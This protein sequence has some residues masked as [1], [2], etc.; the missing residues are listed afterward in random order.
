MQIQG[1]FSTPLRDHGGWQ[2]QVDRE[3][4][5]ARLR[6]GAAVEQVPVEVDRVDIPVKQEMREFVRGSEPL[7]RKNP[8]RDC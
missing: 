7:T 6:W 5:R 8:G 2:D 4:F 1:S 3:R